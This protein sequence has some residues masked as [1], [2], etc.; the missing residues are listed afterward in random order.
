MGILGVRAVRGPA[1]ICTDDNILIT[2][3][4]GCKK[5]KREGYEE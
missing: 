5:D 4:P 1:L 2:R 3:S